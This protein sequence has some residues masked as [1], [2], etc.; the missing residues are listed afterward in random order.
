[1]NIHKLQIEGFKSIG[2]IELIAP[3]PF[4]VFVG[5]NAAGKSNIFEA[6]EFF[7]L[8]DKTD[9][10]DVV[11]LFG[12][13]NDMIHY[14]NQ[15]RSLQLAIIIALDKINPTIYLHAHNIN[16]IFNLTD[17]SS[18]HW[19][20]IYPIED[21]NNRYHSY[22]ISDDNLEVHNSI[23]NN[24]ERNIPHYLK[25]IEYQELT[26]FSRI[27]IN[28][29]DSKVRRRNQDDSRLNSDASNLEKVLKRILQK[30]QTREEISEILQLLI[31]GFDHVE[32][33]TEELSGSDHLLIYETSLNKP[34]NKRLISDGTYNILALIAAIYQSD[35]P[36]F[37]C[38]EEPENGLNPKVVKE[39]VNLLRQKCKEK[40]HYIWL[41]THSQTLVAELTTDEIILVDKVDG[42]TI[43]KQVKG[44]D[45]HGLRM[46]E[47]L[48]TNALGGGIPW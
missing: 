38:I 34:M 3:N 39:L 40:G 12:N 14:S 16:N 33:R 28:E 20:K 36:Q 24:Y 29:P 41:N 11:K 15:E 44:M 6:L 4:S 2:K 26:N 46:D 43:T 9:V 32:I 8:C 45:L 19:G 22:I 21:T 27:R 47:A 42:N 10:L 17:A 18:I 48:M 37:L 30:E 35:T 31:P 7:E 23:D 25:E 5:P 13:F 1:M